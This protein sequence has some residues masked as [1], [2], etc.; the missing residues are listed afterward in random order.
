MSGELK[1]VSEIVRERVL[2]VRPHPSL[3]ENPSK[4]KDLRENDPESPNFGPRG[5]F[6]G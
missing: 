6:G 3:V 1:R 4:I 2:A 5:G